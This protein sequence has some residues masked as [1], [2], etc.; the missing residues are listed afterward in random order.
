[1]PDG[2]EGLLH[3]SE[4]SEGRVNRPEDV[5]KVGEELTL[6]IIKLDTDDRKLG[7]S[8]RAYQEAAQEQGKGE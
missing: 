8:L 3:V 1:L 2:I 4:L 6:K 5:I 7:L